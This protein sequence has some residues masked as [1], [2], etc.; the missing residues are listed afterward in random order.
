MRRREF[1]WSLGTV[2][3]GLAFCKAGRLSEVEAIADRGPVNRVDSQEDGLGIIAAEFPAGVRPVLA[4]TSRVVTRDYAVE[5][6]HIGS[7][8]KEHHSELQ[9]FLRPTKLLPTDGIVKSTATEI[10][11]GADTDVEK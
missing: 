3:A 4:A 5:L 2:S 11:R 1:I 10:T 6:S 7:T 8:S 9:H